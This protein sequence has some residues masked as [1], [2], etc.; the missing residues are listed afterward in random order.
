MWNEEDEDSEAVDGDEGVDE[1][2]AEEENN[3]LTTSDGEICEEKVN[4]K[5]LEEIYEFA[6]TQR[7]RDDEAGSTPEQEEIESG[8]KEITNLADPK[9]SCQPLTNTDGNPVLG[10][11]ASL[12]RS[13]SSLFSDSLRDC[14]EGDPPPPSCSPQ[15]PQAPNLCHTFSPKL[16]GRTL[17]QSSAS[18]VDDVS[19]RVTP[20][21]AAVLPVPGESPDQRRSCE[22]DEGFVLNHG[23]Q[24]PRSIGSNLSP[25]LSDKPHRQE[26]PE[27]IVLSDSNSPP[28]SP[29][30]LKN[31]ESYTQIRPHPRSRQG[32]KEPCSIGVSPDGPATAAQSPPDC[33]PEVSWLVPSTPPPHG[34][35]TS[36]SSTQ[37][38]SSFCRTQLFPKGDSTPLFSSSPDFI[39]KNDV[40]ADAG[41][42]EVHPER[43]AP[44]SSTPLHSEVR[45]P[46]GLLGSSI[47]RCGLDRPRAKSKEPERAE[48][49]GL[50]RSP[51]SDSSDSP[52]SRL[53]DSRRRGRRRTSAE[54]YTRGHLES[55]VGRSGVMDQRESEEASGEKQ[56]EEAALSGFHQSFM[57]MDEP[58]MAFNDSWGL[59]LCPDV[60]PGHFSLRL[61]DSGAG[62]ERERPR[63]QR[64]GDDLAS[65][66][67]L[68]PPSGDARPSPPEARRAS[69]QLSTSLLD[70]KVWDSW[71]E[72][73]DQV[74]PLSQR[75][76]QPARLKTPGRCS[77]PLNTNN[78]EV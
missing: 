19:L 71:E 36:S 18:V 58:P 65:E 57:D 73:D 26:E 53:R 24:G 16:S 14:D 75:V 66:S 52:S 13:Y 56:N 34:R 55:D 37:T 72:E 29:P 30:L 7:R 21:T 10:S 67:P 61:E 35:S 20:P 11:N 47:R 8:E 44:H 41:V 43:R 22:P 40:R 27:L 78:N 38:R 59:N 45:Q 31:P 4:E 51:L 62:S 64:D 42:L 50:H 49:G 46:P 3:E 54:F 70:S 9:T 5:E 39:V 2:K 23:S 48:P 32:F 1:E 77:S 63:Q 15:I 76:N 60:S 28:D 74:L 33:S 25:C 17:L 69:P 12:D 68:T 6:A